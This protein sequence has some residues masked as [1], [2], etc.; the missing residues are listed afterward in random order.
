MNYQLFQEVVLLED[1][2]K[3]GLKSGDVATIVEYHPVAKGEEGYT[4]EIFNV[5][6]DTIGVVTVAASAIGPLMEDEIF[7]V[8]SLAA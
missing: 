7:T 5:L 4:L 3:K 6:G 2:P 1:I 8:R